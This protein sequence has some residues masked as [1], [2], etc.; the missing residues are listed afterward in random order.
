MNKIESDEQ[1]YGE[2]EDDTRNTEYAFA[3]EKGRP[4]AANRKT[5]FVSRFKYL[6]NDPVRM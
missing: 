4:G 1:P 5:P 2:D 6:A 3:A